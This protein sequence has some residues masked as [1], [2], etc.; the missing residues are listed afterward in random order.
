MPESDGVDSL[1]VACQ[2]MT[3]ESRSFSNGLVD[4]ADRG[5]LLENS[6]EVS[7]QYVYS[8]SLSATLFTLSL[9]AL[10]LLAESVDC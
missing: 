1:Q 5:Y 6:T 8:K 3:G 4:S 2:E 10:E 9:M 7:V